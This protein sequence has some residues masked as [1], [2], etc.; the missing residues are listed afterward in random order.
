MKK[1]IR[2]TYWFIVSIF[3]R[4]AAIIIGSLL[5]GIVFTL[6]AERIIALIP[7]SQVSYIGRAGSYDLSKLPLDI[8]QKISSGLTKVDS[9]GKPIPDI[10]VSWNIQESGKTYEFNLDGARKWQDG[11][12]VT[13][14]DIDINLQNVDIERRSDQT[15]IF[16]LND[17][18][19][20][21]PIAV[22]QPL[23][24]KVNYKMYGLF[25]R[26]KII[27]TNEYSITKVKTSGGAITELTLKGKNDT[28]VYR[29][30]PTEEDVITAYML[31]HIDTIEQL[32]IPKKIEGW[33]NTTILKQEHTD[34]YVGLFFNTQD[35]NLSNKSIR[36]ALAYAIPKSNYERRAL[37]PISLNS[38]AYNPQVKPYQYDLMA[39]KEQLS[40]SVG[41]SQLSLTITT[42]LAF[43][44]EAES[45]AKNWKEL[46]IDTQVKIVSFPDTN[47]FQALL[48]G[49]Y[50][51]RDPDQYTYWH[52][53]QGTNFTKYNNPR[54]DKLLEDGRKTVDEDERTLIYQDF[55]RFLI[56]DSPAVFLHYLDSYTV[57]R[58]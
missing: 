25:N 54:I 53:T 32:S 13:A 28:K 24:R 41:Q 40:K 2:T 11:K 1:S 43:V 58:K 48:I 47:D 31:G 44:D 30:Y 4:Y 6:N 26:T 15:I 46:G 55:Q 42:T 17:P 39:A 35:P 49:Q 5:F 7:K 37:S 29:F 45:I 8:Q 52:S 22:S 33:K 56:E 21:F 9:T 3:K 38:W 20:P 57:N 14:A 27:G 19:S 16:R 34:K 12:P 51:P 36:Q 10:A 50:I 23:F 18:F